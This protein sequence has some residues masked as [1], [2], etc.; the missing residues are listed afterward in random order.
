[1]SLKEQQDEPELPK[2]KQSKRLRSVGLRRGTVAIGVQSL[3]DIA[4]E[5]DASESTRS[6]FSQL[7]LL[8]NEESSSATAIDQP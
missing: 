4:Y 5:N 6:Q 3:E 8:N 7:S 1:M 2:G